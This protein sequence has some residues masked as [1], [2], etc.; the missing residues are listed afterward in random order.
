MILA[1]GVGSRLDPLTRGLPKPLVPILNR[2][3]MEHIARLMVR[4]G[5][6]D[7]YSNTHH[8]AEQIETHFGGGSAI[9]A[10]MHFNREQ[11]LLGTAGG[12]KRIAEST[13]FFNHGGTFLVIGGDD[14]TDLDLDAMLQFHRASQALATI[15]LSAVDEPSHY[16]VVVVDDAGKIVRFV[17]KPPPGTE[18]S[19]LVNT[20]VYLFETAVLDL[21]PTGTFHDF[22]KDVF[23]FLLQQ[24]LP[25]FGYRT[26]AYWRDVGNLSEYREC[27]DDFFEGRLDLDPDAHSADDGVWI[28]EGCSIDRGAALESPCLI[29]AGS[30]IEAG[31][32]VGEKSVIGEGCLIA[33]GTTVSHSILWSGARVEQGTHIVR[34]LLGHGCSVSSNQAIFDAVIVPP[35]ARA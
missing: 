8:L 27:H 2:P 18:P 22:G 14:L 30:R 20:G 9:G 24:G 25:F 16:G 6:D 19:K 32:R 31:A 21:I 35:G 15:A 28:G 4:H 12:L 26:D 10:H 5:F 3:V 23:P 33:G 29:G 17:E 11:E 7:I 13:G 34:S 1:A